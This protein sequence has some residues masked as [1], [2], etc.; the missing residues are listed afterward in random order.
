MIEPCRS[1]AQETGGR[2]RLPDWVPADPALAEA[3]KPW[4]QWSA[5]LLA[6]L[7][8]LHVA[9]AFKHHLIDRDGLMARIWPWAKAH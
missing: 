5:W 3:L 4:H 8:A 1:A 9:A 7:I 2:D 6:T